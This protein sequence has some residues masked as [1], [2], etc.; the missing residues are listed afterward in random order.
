MTSEQNKAR[1]VLLKI[2]GEALSGDTGFGIDPKVL[3]Q[4]AEAIRE[5]QKQGVQTAL[6]IGGGNIFR[7]AALQ[8]AGFDRVA[9]D[10]MGML[11]TIMNGLAMR[12]ELIRQGGSCVLMSAY[13]VPSITTQYSARIGREL[14][15]QGTSVI[16]A[17]G[18]GAPFFTTDT[19]AVLRA[20]ELQC[21]E[22]LKATKVDGV[23]TADPVK[24]PKATRFESLTFKDVIAK[25]LKVMDLTAFALAREHNM[26]IRVFSMAKD[27]ALMRAALGQKEGTLVSD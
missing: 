24:D 5:I 6:V 8:Q 11:A 1:R 15:E 16:I 13:G 25:E 10:Q 26:P 17:G 3:S 23:Y 27:G 2:S 14:L 4:T 18:T 21:S 9:G 7:G 12:E 20:V 22:V 19:A